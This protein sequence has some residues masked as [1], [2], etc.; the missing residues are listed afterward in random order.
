MQRRVVGTIAALLSAGLLAAACG[1]TDAREASGR[2]VAPADTGT[3]PVD[4]TSPGS[5][6]NTDPVSGGTDASTPES[7]AP[8]STDGSSTTNT[9]A[10]EITAE[11]TTTQPPPVNPLTGLEQTDPLLDYRPAV[12]VKIDGHLRA[13]PQFGLERADIV[14]EEIVEGITRFMAVF[15]SDLPEVVGPVR[16]AR[17]QDML[18]VPML[19]TPIFVWSGGNRK[20]SAIV[21][22][23]PVVN[24]S[25]F[26]AS[27]RSVFYRTKKRRGPHNLLARGPRILAVVTET[28]RQPQQLFAYRAAGEIPVGRDVSGV[29]IRMSSTRVQWLWSAEQQ[30]WLRSSDG[31]VHRVESGVQVSADNVVILEVKYARS[32]ADPRSPEAQT[33]GSGTAVVLTGGRLV[34]GTWSRETLGEPWVLRDGSGNV[35]A[36]TPGQTWV[37]LALANRTSVIEL[38]V[39][40]RTV[41]W[42]AN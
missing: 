24:I 34:V 39:D 15:H 41:A 38:G 42:K 25:A 27:G 35:I 6:P 26:T 9:S 19:N 5:A 31:K 32:K 12:V 33:L 23:G 17:T 28:S 4:S 8:E 2:V 10:P 18:I 14:V 29:K 36:L 37:E 16:S 21:K 13:R 11:P 7:S 30:R 3:L 1:P 40:P 22:K 20:V